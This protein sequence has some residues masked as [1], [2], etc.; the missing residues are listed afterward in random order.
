[1]LDTIIQTE[2]F[3]QL[4]GY[5]LF[6][7]LYIKPKIILDFIDTLPLKVILEVSISKPEEDFSFRVIH[8]VLKN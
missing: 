8:R 3:R 4:F 7:Y 5:N 6:T 2:N 1:M